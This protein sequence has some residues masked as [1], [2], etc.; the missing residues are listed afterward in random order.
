M[1]PEIKMRGFEDVGEFFGMFGSVFRNMSSLGRIPKEERISPEFSERIMLA[2]TAVN[3]C[4]YCSFLHTKT[5][6]EKGVELDSIHEILEGELG[7]FSDYE[8]PAVL[9]GQHYA[10]TKGNVSNAARESFITAYGRHK[11]SHIEGYISA[12]CF[13]NLCSNTVYARENISPGGK[14]KLPGLFVYL[15]C[16]PIAFGIK[17]NGE[18]A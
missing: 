2:V 9:Y 14:E 3:K 10:E 7:S 4:A 6:L 8:M 16:K 1:A 17:R 13:G 12:V 18:K 15:L 11:A 5:A